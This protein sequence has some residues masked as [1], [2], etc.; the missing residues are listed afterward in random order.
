MGATVRLQRSVRTTFIEELLCRLLA[1]T[2]LFRIILDIISPSFTVEDRQWRSSVIDIFY[3]FFTAKWADQSVSIIIRYARSRLT[4]AYQ[5]KEIRMAVD[6]YSSTLLP[7][8]FD[9]I[10]LCWN[11]YFSTAPITERTK[12][13]SFLIQLRPHFP[14]WQGNA[15]ALIPKRFLNHA[16]QSLHGIPSSRLWQK[17]T[18]TKR[19]T[20]MKVLN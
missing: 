1:V 5:Q 19:M 17:K 2:R 11:E 8:H 20:A 9:A 7:R 10:S 4:M 12:L 14:S 15:I 16:H 3:Y 6:A 13:V 18:T